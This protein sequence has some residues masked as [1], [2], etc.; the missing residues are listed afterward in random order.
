MDDPVA[1][2]DPY[3][4]A[5]AAMR[6]G[7]R[8]EA[9]QW[10]RRALAADPDHGDALNLLGILAMQ[11]GR[12]AEAE[13]MFARA[14]R[15]APQNASYRSNLGLALRRLERYAE[16]RAACATAVELDPGFA[17]GH[18]NLGLVLLAVNEPAAA[19]GAFDTAVRLRPDYVDALYNRAVALEALG[20]HGQAAQAY[21]ATLALRADYPGAALRQAAALIRAGKADEALPL[22]QAQ[23][24]ADPDN[25]ADARDVLADAHLALAEAALGRSGHLHWKQQRFARAKRAYERLTQIAPKNPAAWNGVGLALSCLGEHA[26][27][28]APLRRSIELRPDY[29]SALN[30]LA[31]ARAAAGA[32]EEA[33]GLFER[34]IG[35]DPK[36]AEGHNNLGA[37]LMAIGRYA[38][39]ALAFGRAATVKPDY[40]GAH[41]NL[42]IARLT[43][44]DF[45]GGWPEYAWRWKVPE[46]PSP[47]RDFKQPRWTGEPLA[48]RTILLHAEQGVGDAIQFIRYAPVLA[49]QGA[50]VLL[51]VP[52]EMI[53][54]LR[55]YD[56][57]FP[58]LARR[59]A[60]PPFDLHCPLLTVP[61]VLGTDL[62]SIPAAVPY[63]SAEAERRA[64]WRERLADLPG[65][66]IGFAWAGNPKHKKDALRSVAASAFAPL[67]A[68]PQT[69]W[70][71]LQVGARAAQIADLPRERV[72]D[73][74][75]W[76]KDFADTAALIAE[77]DLVVSVDTA[78][79]HLAGALGKPVWV[80]IPFCPDWRWMLERADSPWYPTMRL[81]RQ[82]APNDWA[83]A[84]AAIEA[85]LRAG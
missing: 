79:V 65:R 24:E 69:S 6:A 3:R 10:T 84:F 28:E 34:A 60:L 48:G 61:E 38:E 29:P 4:P 25:A 52:S 11:A 8:A 9:E 7:R 19:L 32:H 85:A 83:P 36:F 49:A 43:L 40:A 63:L 75:P 72:F 74:A 33:I 5:A 44:G 47:K 78:V 55:G 62:A 76:L 23:I 26:A 64:A 41:M 42:G 50:Q 22:I 56:P 30:N 68:A 20:R 2:P 18:N 54:L 15:L 31:L 37:S 51:E 81:F 77:L 66:K 67:L 46:F 57:R 39:A 58:V 12:V 1:A 70:V 13:P 71:A 80:L 53:G 17:E 82:S 73:A 21:A 59:S 45:A 35:I 27:A 14:S 16:A